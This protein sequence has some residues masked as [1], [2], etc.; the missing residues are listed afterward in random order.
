MRARALPVGD[1]DRRW[2]EALYFVFRKKM[3]CTMCVTKAKTLISCAVTAQLICAFV[4]AYA[5]TDFLM[6]RH[7]FHNCSKTAYDIRTIFSHSFR[8]LEAQKVI[9]VE[10]TDEKGI[11]AVSVGNGIRRL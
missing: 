11:I 7:I 2:Q 9:T 1:N 5:K 3:D 4:F 6:T 8:K 10:T